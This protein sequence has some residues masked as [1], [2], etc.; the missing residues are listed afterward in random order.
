MSSLPGAG[1]SGSIV[2]GNP[3]TGG[4]RE[5]AVGRVPPLTENFNEGVRVI[6]VVLRVNIS[7]VI[8][9]G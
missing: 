3:G 7:P 1:I 9:Y 6:P 5:E 2:C 4:A 8:S